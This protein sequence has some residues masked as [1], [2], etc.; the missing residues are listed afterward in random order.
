[1]H[2]QGCV[3]RAAWR[4]ACTCV[5]V[6]PSTCMDVALHAL[7]MYFGHTSCM[8]AA[9]KVATVSAYILHVYCMHYAFGASW[10]KITH[11]VLLCSFFVH[12]GMLFCSDIFLRGQ[13]MFP[14]VYVA[15]I[16]YAFLSILYACSRLCAFWHADEHKSNA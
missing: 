3:P 1:M 15:C 8:H 2:A 4:A 10:A 7:V 13:D 12:S 5:L 14:F 6:F 11:A 9:S 16:G